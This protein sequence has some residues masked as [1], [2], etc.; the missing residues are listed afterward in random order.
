MAA[1][2]T[3]AATPSRAVNCSTPSELQPAD[4]NA[5][6]TAGTSIASAVSSQNFDQLQASLL[7]AVTRD[8]DSIRGVAQSAAPILKGGTLHW[9]DGYLLDASSLKEPADTDFF[10]SAADSSATIT[11]SLRNLPAGRYARGS[12]RCRRYRPYRSRTR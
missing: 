12:N 10:C 11:I 4:R 9:G 3:L 2:I 7:P 1:L 6:L 5:L 8:W